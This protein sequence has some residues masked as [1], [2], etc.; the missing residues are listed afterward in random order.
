MKKL[1]PI[2][3]ICLLCNV[4]VAGQIQQYNL[5]EMNLKGR[6]RTIRESSYKAVEKAG[7][8]QKDESTG[9]VTVIDFNERGNMIVKKWLNTDG[10]IDRK[11][12]CRYDNTGHMI[13]MDLLDGWENL[14]KKIT[15]KYDE[16]GKMIEKNSY[17]PDGS[18]DERSV[19]KYTKDR[20]MI[21][22]L[23]YNK[24]GDRDG[25][26]NFQYDSLWNLTQ[27]VFS[28]GTFIKNNYSYD[29]YGNAIE[30]IKHSTGSDFRDYTY[31]YEYDKN[32]NWIKK[33]EFVNEAQVSITERVIIYF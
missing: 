13:E 7:A 27:E 22:E 25:G 1:I 31:K 21:D 8:V 12:T 20:N 26:N 2:A 33:D 18:L 3:V 6:V 16:N 4:T 11:D 29:E 28:R 23:F 32:F 24:N 10:S 9:S 14:E 15:F 5:K 30:K 19:Y 17:N